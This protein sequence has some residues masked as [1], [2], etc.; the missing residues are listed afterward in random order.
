MSC[1]WLSG[2]FKSDAGARVIIIIII[3]IIPGMIVQ[4]QE[5]IC[6]ERLFNW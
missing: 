6:S 4:A 5:V 2:F 3:T 1:F